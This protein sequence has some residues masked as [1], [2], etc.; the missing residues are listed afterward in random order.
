M[1]PISSTMLAA[2]WICRVMD[3][4]KMLS[5]R[6]MIYPDADIVRQHRCVV[7]IRESNKKTWFIR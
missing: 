1:P 3:V 6:K 2:V 7:T 5:D 4:V